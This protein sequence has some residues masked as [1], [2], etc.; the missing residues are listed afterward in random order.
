VKKSDTYLCIYTYIYVR[1]DNEISVYSHG[2]FKSSTERSQSSWIISRVILVQIALVFSSELN[3]QISFLDVNNR[4]FLGNSGL[5][6]SSRYISTQY[7]YLYMFTCLYVHQIYVYSSACVMQG[8]MALYMHIHIYIY[9]GNVFLEY[10]NIDD[11]TRVHT[12]TLIFTCICTHIYT[13]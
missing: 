10:V 1:Y 3:I 13:C 11:L 7:M 4:N 2:T 5:R 6:Q 8:S 9:S 12:Y